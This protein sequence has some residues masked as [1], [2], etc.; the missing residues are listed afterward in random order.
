MILGKLREL[1]GGYTPF[2]GWGTTSRAYWLTSVA[3]HFNKRIA[4]LAKHKSDL[5][6]REE[7]AESAALRWALRLRQGYYDILF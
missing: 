2:G 4:E 7:L 5:A 6:T 1:R 3:D